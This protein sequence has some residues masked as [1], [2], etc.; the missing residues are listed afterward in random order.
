MFDTGVTPT[1]LRDRARFIRVF[2]TICF[3]YYFFFVCH[4]GLIPVS[5]SRAILV[6]IPYFFLSFIV[7]FNIYFLI[8]IYLIGDR[9]ITIIFIFCILIIINL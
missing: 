7:L 4:T 8:L 6:L 2:R 1:C 5:Y 9:F 3:F